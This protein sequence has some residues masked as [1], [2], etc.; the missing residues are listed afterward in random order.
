[1]KRTMPSLLLALLA[2][3]NSGVTSAQTHLR[4]QIT[5]SAPVEAPVTLE[6]VTV[7]AD[8]RG[9]L[10]M[11]SVDMVFH[12]PNA[13]IL[14]GEL[15]FPL[16]DGQRVVGLA[17]DLDGRLR[18]GVP[19]DKALGQAVFEEVTRTRI[20][21]ALLQ[22]T[23]GNNYKMRVY[24]IPA[25]GHKRVVIRYAETL[26]VNGGQRV[27][28]LPLEYAARLVSLELTLLVAD[29]APKVLRSPA[30]FGPLDFRHT[31]SFYS[32]RVSRE[33]FVARGVLELA[34]PVSARPQV[35]AQAAHGETYFYAEL[36]VAA[37]ASPR[38]LPRVVGLLWDS[39]GSG[40]E[41]D[42]DR[43]FALLDAYFRRARNVEVHLVLLREKAE[44]ASVFRV[45]E[46]NWQALRAVLKRVIY[47]GA[48]DL[49]SLAAP[50]AEAGEWLLF[51]DG[52]ANYGDRRTTIPDR[53]VYTFS[54]G[55]RADPA[56]LRHIAARSG[57]R[58]I[59]L[60]L[61]TATEAARLLL[62]QA[63]RIAALEADG[64]NELV[65][66][67]PHPEHGRILFAGRMA[68]AAA[69]VQVTMER[70]GAR[71][72]PLRIDVGPR[73][74]PSPYAAFMWAS[75]RVA[76]LDGDYRAN[77]DAIRRIGKTFGIVTRE[78][79]LIVLDRIEDYVRFEI[80]PPVE[81]VPAYDRLLAARRQRVASDKRNQIERVAKLFMEKQAWWQRS[82][83]KDEPPARISKQ[84]APGARDER[85]SLDAAGR[86]GTLSA[87]RS[88]AA[89]S[90]RRDNAA[91]AAEA[92]ATGD[93]SAS[94]A[95]A[96]SIQL[97]RWRPDAPYIERFA[98]AEP[99]E[100]YSIYLE[101]RGAHAGSTAFILDAADQLLEKG[102]TE[103]GLR[104]LSNLAEMDLENRHIL[105]VL[106]YRLLQ[107]GASRLA[108]P[109]FERVLELS[110][111]EPQSYRDLGLAY[112]A[113]RQFQKAVDML[114]E[115]V[116]RPWHG[117]FPEV[118]LIALAELNAI[119]AQAERAGEPVD[120]SRV[121]AR[122]RR[123]LALDI[124]VV[125]TWDADN[126]DIDLWVTDPNG[127]KAYYG[128]RHTYQGGRMSPDYTGGYGPEEFGLREA[129]PGRYLVQVNFYGHR[130]QIVA[131]A[132]TLQVKLITGF[133]T[134]RERERLVTLRLR[135][136]QEVVTVGEFE[137][138]AP[139]QQ[140]Q[141][142]GAGAN[143]GTTRVD[144]RQARSE[145]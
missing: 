59:D 38:P 48:T 84:T 36:P 113:E 10:A 121:D 103:L 81:L 124:R 34:V 49:A 63:P 137:I 31:G 12:N 30:G 25:R 45:R 69:S 109:I 8:I 20:D 105:R 141:V 53:P 17:M 129:K 126:T 4:P 85:R 24:P 9:S 86:A 50:G 132:T 142:G 133:G 112:A 80:R 125:A 74:A 27:Y 68:T 101:E 90:A 16:L 51:S 130:Q 7:Q 35:Y 104:V 71:Q 54:S 98:S 122:L 95:P 110:P 37:T 2:V 145:G 91:R 28:R 82:Y 75:M 106:G 136:R 40:A 135:E 111:E 23:A 13:R 115:V 138:G 21:P 46:G 3:A 11:T 144:R 79:S 93:P 44:P 127:E 41:R 77:R 134:A 65:A 96:P 18:D 19:V 52:I 117:R 70:G 33:Q 89:P 56:A 55:T 78:T 67:S 99:E 94:A 43:E 119:A 47:D 92:R 128:H 1:M 66:A 131:G 72:A 143:S 62:T 32:A 120:L 97:R 107:A 100:L 118:E 6:S 22:V 26:V 87:P 140:L 123:N 60:L 116:Q 108:L 15:Q 76:A 88:A 139:A 61:H 114:Y 73:T 5:V 64:A 58:H 57:G 42:H 83:P 102:Q 14:E 39:S 29:A